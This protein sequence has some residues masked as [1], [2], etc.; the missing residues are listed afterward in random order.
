MLVLLAPATAESRSGNQ[1]SKPFAVC[2][3]F[4]PAVSQSGP[5]ANELRC[6]LGV[7]RVDFA[8]S[9]AGP[10]TLRKQT[11]QLAINPLALSAIQAPKLVA[12][13]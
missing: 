13:I 10:L 2:R 6:L 1:L 5:Y 12:E 3:R 11:W 9:A 8:M 7:N 4:V